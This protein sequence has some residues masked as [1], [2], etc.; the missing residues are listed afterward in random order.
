MGAF[1]EESRTRLLPGADNFEMWGRGFHMFV[2][3]ASVRF[4]KEASMAQNPLVSSWKAAS[5]RL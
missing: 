1:K 5:S 4:A 2:L 3:F